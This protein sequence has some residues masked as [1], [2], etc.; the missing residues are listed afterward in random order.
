MIRR[1]SLLCL[2][3]VMSLAVAGKTGIETARAGA[4]FDGAWTV[5]IMTDRGVCESIHRLNV[6]IHDGALAYSDPQTLQLHGHVS[7][8]GAVQVHVVT[9]GQSA[10]GTG[11]LTSNSGSGT[12]RG[13][14]T[15]G[16]CTGHWMAER[17]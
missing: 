17:A 13:A 1:T 10:N 12:W 3:T 14:G 6:D 15:S 11:H 7:N 4:A 8:D 5:K 2:L 16:A 9:G